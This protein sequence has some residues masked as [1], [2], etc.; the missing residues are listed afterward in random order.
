MDRLCGESSMLGQWHDLELFIIQLQGMFVAHDPKAGA[1][2]DM[3]GHLANEYIKE[4]RD[5]GFSQ[6]IQVRTG[7]TTKSE[8]TIENP[9][10][11]TPYRTFREVKQPSSDFIFRLRNTNNNLQCALFEGDG[12]AWELEAVKN[13][14]A[15]L[16]ERVSIPVIA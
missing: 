15:Y 11:L 16:Q 4:N 5:D 1:I 12:G 13:I 8:V 3:L 14:A 9:I 7:I 2:I 10:C 6:S